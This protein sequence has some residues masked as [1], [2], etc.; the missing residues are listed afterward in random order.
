M[1][2]LGLH[3]QQS[4][5]LIGTGRPSA[6][7][8]FDRAGRL[9]GIT[10]VETDEEIVDA[11]G[12]DAASIAVDAPLEIPN[13]LGQRPVE[14]L[15]AWCDIPA[16]PVSRARHLQI[17][18]GFRAEDLAGRLPGT[19]IVAQTLPDLALRL[20]AWHE[21]PDGGTTDL[22]AYRTRWLG[23][24]PPRFRAKGSGRAV[25]AGILSAWHLAARHVDLGGWTPEGG[26]DDWG[27]IR[28]AAAIDAIACGTVAWRAV[29]EP[30]STMRIGDPETGAMLIPVDNALRARLEIHLHRLAGH[31]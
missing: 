9:A 14:R 3:L 2:I 16:F 1:R 18:G 10:F 17:H 28:D 4:L 12:H 26:D 19:A 11:V 21:E 27:A 25:P 24:R 23:I 6:L 7:A 29:H 31:G 8:E 22:A 13:E 5:A 20:W 30:G 15:L